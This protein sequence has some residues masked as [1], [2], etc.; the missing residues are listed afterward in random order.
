MAFVARLSL[1]S[2][3]GMTALCLVPSE[4]AVPG[5]MLLAHE[6]WEHPAVPHPTAVCAN[7]NFLVKS[8]YINIAAV[9]G[10]LL[11]IVGPSVDHHFPERLPAHS[12]AYIGQVMLKHGHIYDSS[13]DVQPDSESQSSVV[14]TTGGTVSGYWMFEYSKP[15]ALIFVA[16]ISFNDILDPSD[17]S[18]ENQSSIV[19]EPPPPRV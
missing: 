4:P 12:H 16:T 6:S 1:V 19:P 7:L 2:H 10:L 8:H 15:N 11:L 18:L 3:H 5:D 9:F 17:F 14:K 13:P